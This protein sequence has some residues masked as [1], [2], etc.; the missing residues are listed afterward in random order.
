M[1]YMADLL[2]NLE[3]IRFDD[4]AKNSHIILL[5]VVMNQIHIGI[6]SKLFTHDTIGLLGEFISRL[7]NIPNDV[8]AKLL[9]LMTMAFQIRTEYLKE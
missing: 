6:L 7:T 1:A 4:T 2:Q 9:R 3:N 5:V 8:K